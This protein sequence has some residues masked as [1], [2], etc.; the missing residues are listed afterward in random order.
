MYASSLV[1]VELLGVCRFNFTLAR[2]FSGFVVDFGLRTGGGSSDGLPRAAEGL[3]ECL[4]SRSCLTFFRRGNSSCS[5]TS[6]GRFRLAPL[7]GAEKNPAFLCL[8]TIRSCFRTSL[9]D[10]RD[11]RL[12]RCEF[13]SSVSSN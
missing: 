9:R 11:L 3:G 6:A 7:L 10:K 8:L 12:N 1:S 13:V 2:G 4:V 5:S